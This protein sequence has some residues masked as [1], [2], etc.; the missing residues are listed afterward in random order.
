[1]G[2]PLDRAVRYFLL[3]DFLAGFRLGFKYFFKPK[4][5]EVIK[6][7]FEIIYSFQ[8]TADLKIA[9][10][11]EIKMR[12]PLINLSFCLLKLF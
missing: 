5:F 2:M 9:E 3:T 6:M 10:A 7:Q 11:I 4:A 8:I 1:M 12:N